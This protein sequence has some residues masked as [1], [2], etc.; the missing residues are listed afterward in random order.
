MENYFLTSEE[1]MNIQKYSILLLILFNPLYSHAE[2]I[3]MPSS[4]HNSDENISIRFEGLLPYKAYWVGVYDKVSSNYWGNVVS[5]PLEDIRNGM[6]GFEEIGVTGNYEVRLFYKDTYNLVDRFE[7]T[8]TAKQDEEESLQ[9]TKEIFSPNETIRVTTN[10]LKNNVNYWL[11][12]FEKSSF[13]NWN[14]VVSWPLENIING[15]INFESISA[16]GEYE[17]RLFYYDTTQLVGSIGFSVE[18]IDCNTPWYSASLTHYTSYP[19]PNS[20]ECKY[21]NGCN[22]AGQFYGLRDVQSEEWVA[23]TN[24]VAVHMKD[25]DWLGSKKIRI[26]QGNNEIVAMAYDACSDADCDGCCTENLGE[27]NFLLDLEENTMQRFGSGSG[28]VQ[29]QVCD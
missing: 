4:L 3:S 12:I 27:N 22:W 6:V 15:T 17:V 26:R 19:D 20:E 2:S 23:K 16:P 11:G 29:F 21:Y 18:P 13:N 24:I 7:F 9:L 25:W 1:K 28:T 8:V 14:N 5:W 10:H